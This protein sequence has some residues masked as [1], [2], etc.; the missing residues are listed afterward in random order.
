MLKTD[1]F[2]APRAVPPNG[3]IQVISRAAAIL[4]LLARE[5]GGLSLGQIASSVNLPRSTVQRIVSALASEELVRQKT[6][7]GITLGAGIQ[8]LALAFGSSP[9]DRL[10]PIM[11]QIADET[12]E[13]VDL[14]VLKSGQM[15]F[16]DQII[17]S[18]RL[19]TVSSI[20]DTFPLTTTA[21][22]K[23]ALACLDELA[24]TNLILTELK[25]QPVSAIK[26]PGLL[27][28]IDGI[29]DGTLARDDDEHTE[30][31]SALG[32]GFTDLSGAIYAISVPVPTSRFKRV[33]GE[34]VQ[35]LQSAKKQL[36]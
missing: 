23:A 24:A 15:L 22:G 27:A 1:H 2:A 20:G 8:S 6:G 32:F 29:R 7:Q 28:E 4:R 19:R 18:H 11:Q 3:K 10:R 21:N 12:G 5:T 13:T 35:S 26:L 14:A 34:L 9:K 17:G 33:E 25:S 16:I 31:I 30:G 36:R